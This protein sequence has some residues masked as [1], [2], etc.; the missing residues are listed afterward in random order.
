MLRPQ[1]LGVRARIADPTS[2]NADMSKDAM[3]PVRVWDLPTRLFHWVLAL[4][5]LGSVVTAK[6]GGNAMVWHFRLGYL[7]LGLLLF[8][9]AWGL[10]GGRWSRFSSFAW[11]PAALLR[12]LRARPLAGERFDVGH[13]PL[14]A[15]SVFAMLGLLAL[16]VATG[17]FAD[18]EIANVGPLNR[19]VSGRAA[20]WMTDLHK[21]LG[22]VVLVGLIAL[23][24]AAVAFHRVVRRLDLIRPMLVGDKHLPPDTPASDDR[25]PS[26]LLALALASLVG[27][28]VLAFVR[29]AESS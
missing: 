6:I 7:A 4:S 20:H 29:W 13:S 1:A 16:Q 2:E 22:G 10:V 14:A 5:V 24:L 19:W 9:L 17:L 21:T 25:W 8:R 23:H 26:R 3:E 15:L 11:G 28:A 12:Y 27:L 18:D